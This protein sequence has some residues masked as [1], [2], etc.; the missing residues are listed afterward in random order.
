VDVSAVVWCTGF[1]PSYEFLELP[2]C[3]FDDKGLPIA[4]HGIVGQIPGL[5]FVGLPFQVGLTST[6]VGGAGRDAGLVVRHIAQ[7]RNIAPTASRHYSF[8]L[9]SRRRVGNFFHGPY[10]RQKKIVGSRKGDGFGN[11]TNHEN[12]KL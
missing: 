8:E 6:L 9:E 3:P 1:R 7:Q 2:D 11:C 12:V 4:P 10:T 5:Y